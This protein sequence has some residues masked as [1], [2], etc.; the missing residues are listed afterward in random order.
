[1]NAIYMAPNTLMVSVPLQASGGFTQAGYI[2][3]TQ[4]QLFNHRI[5]SVEAFSSLDIASD[6]NNSGYTA[7]PPSVFKN[8]F[9]TLYSSTQDPDTTQQP[10]LW[11]D[12]IPM[13][14]MRMARN[15]DTELSYANGPFII[16]PTQMSFNKCKVEF[17]TTTALADNVSAVFLFTYLD[18]GDKGRSWM[19]VPGTPGQ[20]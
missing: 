12:K 1:M 14:K 16:R 18:I 9:L 15:G 11:Y 20:R 17:P 8:A 7:M 4:Q 3:P 13:C 2:F 6:P 10:G 19:Q 5:V